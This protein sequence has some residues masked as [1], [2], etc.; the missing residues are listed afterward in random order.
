MVSMKTNSH[1]LILHMVA[2]NYTNL[3]RWYPEK[4]EKASELYTFINF[5]LIV[6]NIIRIFH[7]QF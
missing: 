4:H 1:A 6:L 3:G 7:A 5:V 2:K